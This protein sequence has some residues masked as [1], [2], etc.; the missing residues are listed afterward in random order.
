MKRLLIITICSLM[1][2]GCF[3]YVQP[4]ETHIEVTEGHTETVPETQTEV[5]TVTE[6][7]RITETEQI[8]ETETETEVV[9]ETVTVYV[10][11]GVNIR[12][13]Q[14]KLSDRL[15]GAGFGESF[16]AYADTLEDEF[17]EVVYGEGTA[18]AYGRCLTTDYD[19]ISEMRA[20]M[21][22]RAQ[23]EKPVIAET[24]PATTET[25]TVSSQVPAETETEAQ[26]EAQTTGAIYTPD[27]FKL[28]GV[29]NWGGSKWTYYSQR[30]LPGEGLW[31][32]GRHLDENGYVCDENGYIVCAADL[33]YIPRYTVIDTPL[34]K[35]GKIYDTGCAYG[36][37]DVYTDW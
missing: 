33:S 7:E 36:V 8:T 18:F 10:I 26:T 1:L 31:I 25:E 4:K 28:H 27:Y 14:T 13:Q 16:E 30:I 5:E 22:R 6:T 35:Q 19:V 37:I 23:T 32:P 21:S 12:A 34:G 9:R 29:L 11:Q 20:E 24:E 3:D 17:V 2:A 15:G